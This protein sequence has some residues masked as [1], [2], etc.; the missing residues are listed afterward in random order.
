[1]SY[2]CE[3]AYRG[4]EPCNK[5]VHPLL[6]RAISQRREQLGTDGLYIV[7]EDHLAKSGEI[8][9]DCEGECWL[10]RADDDED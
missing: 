6:H 5:Y 9:I 10:V 3:C 4:A 7:H 8:Q 1:M 2:F